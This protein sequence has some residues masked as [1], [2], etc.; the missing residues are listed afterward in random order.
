L[1]NLKESYFDLSTDLCC[2]C[3]GS[4]FI[5][6]NKAWE[7][8]LGWSTE[9]LKSRP[10]WEF[11]HP[12]DLPKSKDEE[13]RVSSGEPLSVFEN[14]YRAKN[15]EYHLLAWR[16]SWS[17]EHN[18]YFAIAKDI[19]EVRHNERL[20]A[21]Q[22]AALFQKS[23]LTSLGEMASGIAHEINNPLA[24]IN[25]KVYMLRKMLA[26]QDLDKE[27][28]LE[29][30][31][32]IESTTFRISKIV[33]GLKT[34]SR[35]GDEDPFEWISLKSVLDDTFEL[36]A[37]KLLHHEIEFSVNIP[38]A[39]KIRCRP[40][41]IGQVF[42]NLILNSFD[43][44]KNNKEKWIRIEYFISKSGLRISLVDSGLGIPLETADKIL[45]PFFTTKQ[46]GNGMG[47]GLSIS[48]GIMQNHSGRLWYDSDASNTCF[49]IEF[50][51]DSVT[52]AKP[53]EQRPLNP[54]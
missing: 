24:I 47:L 7:D 23:R 30:L 21:E 27:K 46:V 32:K 11:I 48:A 45:Q 28:M 15:G 53:S 52:V 44:I 29:E 8:V 50:P 36:C 17:I 9:E 4:Y 18:M 34:F 54:S 22:R 31:T 49:H 39:I 33:K 35:S 2:V 3:R 38:A 13:S 25:G 43:A 6:V 1:K 12:D 41:Q 42:S 16:G 19:T 37:E 51:I 14:R 10:Y 26:Q 5:E 40:V 20:L